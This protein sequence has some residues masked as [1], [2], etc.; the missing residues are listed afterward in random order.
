M[1][2]ST[3]TL[4]Q[5]NRCKKSK[6]YFEV[7]YQRAC[8]EF[9]EQETL[10]KSYWV[11]VST[12]ECTCTKDTRCCY[13]LLQNFTLHF[14]VQRHLCKDIVQDNRAGYDFK[15]EKALRDVIWPY[16]EQTSWE[17]PMSIM[18]NTYFIII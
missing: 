9:R 11:L 14:L 18:R 3:L 7:E 1:E 6:E 10:F 17:A 13:Y 5:K 16:S 12:G 15:C 8:K 2:S 4:N